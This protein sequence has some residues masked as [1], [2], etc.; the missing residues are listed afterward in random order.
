MLLVVS[1]V[2]EDVTVFLH[3]TLVLLLAAIAA[4]ASGWLLTNVLLCMGRGDGLL[5]GSEQKYT[6]CH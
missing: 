6:V 2:D 3:F 4:V 5:K 1:T